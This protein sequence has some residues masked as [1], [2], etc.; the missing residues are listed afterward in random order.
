MRRTISPSDFREMEYEKKYE[1]AYFCANAE[2]L[3]SVGKDTLQ[4]IICFLLYAEE[5]IANG[6]EGSV[7]D[8]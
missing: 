4:E 3:N 2:T 6:E 5:A 8:E 7:E 1:F